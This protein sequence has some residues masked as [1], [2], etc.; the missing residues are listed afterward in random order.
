LACQ[1]KCVIRFWF[2]KHS[3]GVFH[4]GY[5]C[6]KQGSL[7]CFVLLCWDEILPN[8]GASCCALVS[9][10]SFWWVGVHWLG[11]RLFGATVWRKLLIIESFSQWKMNKIETENCIGI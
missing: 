9:S 3:V 8:H 1:K 2:W 5:L 11:L 10:K 4:F 7:F 6:M